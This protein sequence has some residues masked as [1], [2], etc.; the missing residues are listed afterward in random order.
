MSGTNNKITKC[1]EVKKVYTQ[2]KNWCFTDFENVSLEHWEN[3]YNHE[4]NKEC[5]RYMC[6]GLEVCPTTKKEHIQGWIQTTTKRRMGGI[7]RI[8]R[9]KK[10]HVEACRGDEYDNDKY[11][12]KDGKFKKLGKFVSQGQRTDL[13]QMIDQLKQSKGNLTK[14]ALENPETYCRYRNGIKDFAQMIKEEASKEFRKLNVVVL[15][16]KTGTGKTRTA[17]EESIKISG[18]YPY[19]TT[20]AQ[21]ATKWWDGY[22]NQSA[23]VIDEYDSQIAC[24]EMLNILDGYQLRLQIKGGFTYAMYNT[25]YITSNV[26][27]KDWH[28]HAKKEHKRALLRRITEI[29]KI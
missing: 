28:P 16:G 26:H 12:S 2:S 11:C 10:I 18:E 9:S 17:M 22:E 20:G 29:R 1:A 27:P 15:Y 3:I 21:M 13:E 14:V 8:L 7:K 23:L 19:K 25:V 6:F 24:T 4:S 5:I